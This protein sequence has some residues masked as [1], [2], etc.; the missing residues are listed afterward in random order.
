MTREHIAVA[1]ALSI[2]LFVV[3]TKIDI[4]PEKVL[5]L[6]QLLC[7]CCWSLFSARYF[8]KTLKNSPPN[9]VSTISLKVGLK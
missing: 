1:L 6:L 2:P 3:C 7:G 9:M 4:A 8:A 5:K